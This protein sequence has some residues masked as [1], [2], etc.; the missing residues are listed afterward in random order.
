MKFGIRKILNLAPE[1]EPRW[2]IKKDSENRFYV[3]SGRG[4]DDFTKIRSTLY[5][6][7]KSAMSSIEE[8]ETAIAEF[9]KHL[10]GEDAVT[11]KTIR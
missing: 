6:R 7:H 2:I 4:L 9:E 3:Q 5:F 10:R 1:P 8:C 11:V